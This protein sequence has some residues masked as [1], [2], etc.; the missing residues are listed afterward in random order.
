MTHFNYDPNLRWNYFGKSK[1]KPIHLVRVTLGMWEYRKSIEIQIGGNCLGSS[2]IETALS[3]AFEEV[4]GEE[5]YVVLLLADSQGVEL[6]VEL[7]E[8][9]P[10]GEKPERDERAEYVFNNMV[11]GVEIIDFKLVAKEQS[12][13]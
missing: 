10:D 6:E 8:E 2:I 3:M 13:D 5:N 11:L 9:Y 4:M 12:N 7:W 1:E